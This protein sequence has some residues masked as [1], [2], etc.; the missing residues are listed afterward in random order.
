M[1][2][3]IAGF[4]IE[5]DLNRKD[6]DEDSMVLFERFREPGGWKPV[7]VRNTGTSLPSCRLNLP[8]GKSRYGRDIPPLWESCMQ[9]NE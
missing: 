5:N 1:T 9:R 3:D 6:D 2:I 7:L 8:D 4:I